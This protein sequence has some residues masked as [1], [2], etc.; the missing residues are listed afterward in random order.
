M[1]AWDVEVQQIRDRGFAVFPGLVPL[2]MCDDVLAAIATCCGVSVDDEATWSRIS[3]KLD[4][5]P[6]WGSQAQWNVRQLPAVHEIWSALWGRND[7]WADMNSCRVT[8]PWRE[9]H[10]DALAIHFDVD[11]HDSSQQWFQGLVTLTD[12]PPGHGGFR[13]VPSMYQD[14]TT[15]PT[16]WLGEGFLPDT[17]G[18]EIIEVSLRKG[19]LLVWDAHLPHGTVRNYG[20]SPRAVMYFQLHPPGN[21]DD[22]SAWLDD[23]REGRCPPWW[24]W[25]PGHDRLDPQPLELTQLGRRLLGSEP[26]Y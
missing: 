16:E 9:G 24:R 8:P 21:A 11:P 20:S 25:K 10:A 13:C 7:L 4:Q 18:H 2:A 26:W 5:V 6:L 19:D 23:V 15:W 22:L 17:S 1:V 12:A 14:R 3:T